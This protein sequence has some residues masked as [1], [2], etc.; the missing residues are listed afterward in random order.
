[1]WEM[2]QKM[3]ISGSE[4]QRSHVQMEH[5]LSSY[6]NH[7]HKIH[8]ATY[9]DDGLR[10]SDLTDSQRFCKNQTGCQC[11]VMGIHSKHLFSLHSFRLGATA[12]RIKRRNQPQKVKSYK[13]YSRWAERKKKKDD[14]LPKCVVLRWSIFGVKSVSRGKCL[15]MFFFPYYKMFSWNY[16]II[17]PIVV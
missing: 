13:R 5:F 16:E 15:S 8:W 3:S 10:L 6:K 4:S 7:P 12:S 17:M 9:L 1:M 11:F 2:P 14:L